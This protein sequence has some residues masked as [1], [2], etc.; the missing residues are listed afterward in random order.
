M[1]LSALSLYHINLKPAKK[2]EK[3]FIYKIEIGGTEHA[4]RLSH[5]TYFSDDSQCPMEEIVQR[6]ILMGLDD[7]AFTEHVDYGVNMV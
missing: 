2:V 7:I 1:G 4:V 3:S 6:A 5:T